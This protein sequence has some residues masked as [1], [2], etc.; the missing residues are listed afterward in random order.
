M[1]RYLGADVHAASVTFSVLSESGKQ[2]RHDVVET[3]GQALVGYLR[4]IPGTLHL[5]I[6]EGEWSQWLYEILSPHVAEMLVV[7]GEWKPGS[8]S[9]RID[10]RGWA[11][12]LRTGQLKG[13]VYKDA[14]RF[15]ALRE[16]A[17]AYAMVTRDLARVKNRIKS[18]YRSRGVACSGE[19]VYR[20][21]ERAERARELPVATRQAVELL[22]RELD[23]LVELKAEAEAAMLRESHRHPIARVL[24]TAPGF[25]PVRVAE[26]LPIVITPW[27]FRTK[28]QFWAYCGFG[29]VTRSSS[30]WIREGRRWVRAPVLQTRG[31]NFNFN[32]T[33]KAVFKG[34]ATTVIAHSGPNPLR[35]KYDELL[36]NGTKPN[37]AKLTI[38][39]QIAAIVLAQWKTGER[40]EPGR[41]AKKL[42]PAT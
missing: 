19:A 37:L 13:I 14:K 3:N 16:R 32:R 18:F 11:E 31:L 42:R 2:L 23:H 15:T 4:Q 22:G 7:R 12:K 5:C 34:A 20:P 6:E 26:V 21:E 9:D 25:G 1:E 29:V 30:D 27:R 40:Y 41:L 17:R 38:A 36:E 24:E 28:R 10:A 39:R 35:R 8:K 33:L